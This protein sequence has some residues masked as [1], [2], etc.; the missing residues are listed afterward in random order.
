[1]YDYK[2]H[3]IILKYLNNDLSKGDSYNRYSDIESELK[4][5]KDFPPHQYKMVVT[6]LKGKGY[7]DIY[8]SHGKIDYGTEQVKITDLGRRYVESRKNIITQFF[9]WAKRND[10]YWKVVNPILGFITG[11]L[12]RKYGG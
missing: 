12:L 7:I 6:Y 11:Y 3:R 5:Y 2:K 9:F 10:N 1:M 8:E 4:K